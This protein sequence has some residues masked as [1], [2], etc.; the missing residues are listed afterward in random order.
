LS[1]LRGSEFLLCQMRRP[2]NQFWPAARWTFKGGSRR[3]IGYCLATGG[4]LEPCLTT[5]A[6]ADGVVFQLTG[7]T[8][9]LL[10]PPGY[11]SD[12]PHSAAQMQVGLGDR[13][14]FVAGYD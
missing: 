6:P 13:R 14:D 10:R 12:H 1:V 2:R 3:G 5:R 9:T 11:N 4:S 7:H 8:K